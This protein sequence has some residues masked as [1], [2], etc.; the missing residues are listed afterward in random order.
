MTMSTDRSARWIAL[1]VILLAAVMAAGQAL[2]IRG[3][4]YSAEQVQ[5]TVGSPLE[6][7]DA[8]SSRGVKGRV[9][10][11]LDDRT[12]IVPRTW[13]ATFM[14]SLQDSTVEPP[15]MKH[16]FTS[17]LMYAGIAREVYFCPPDGAW[18]TE[19]DRV[20]R[21]PDSFPEGN[22]A[23]V[24]F[25]GT[26]VHLIRSTDMPVFPEKVVVYIAEGAASRYDAAFMAAI[27]DPTVADVIV[28]QVTE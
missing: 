19:L 20:S 12:R 10:V 14:D 17:C 9:L 16:N 23:R 1:A 8:L 6:A 3:R 21:R 27:T 18:Q 22:G 26:P 13:M 15:V 7:Y 4:V 25:Y 11:L 24:R 5:I 2:A 28:R